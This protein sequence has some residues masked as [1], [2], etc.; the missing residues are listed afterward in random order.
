MLG[1]GVFGE[2]IDVG[3]VEASSTGFIA[4]GCCCCCC[5]CCKDGNSV[6][7]ALFAC[8]FDASSSDSSLRARFR[9]AS[10]FSFPVQQFEL[11]LDINRLLGL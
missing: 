6:V 10:E 2:V 1:D 8:R 5:C 11:F 4:A 9:A 3:V 7:A